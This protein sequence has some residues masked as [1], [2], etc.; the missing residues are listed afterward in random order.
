MKQ[1]KVDENPTTY[2]NK[3]L[4]WLWKMCEKIAHASQP[5]HFPFF[6]DT[7]NEQGTVRSVRSIWF[8]FHE[9]VGARE[10]CICEIGSA[11]SNTTVRETLKISLSIQ[12]KDPQCVCVR[13][14]STFWIKWT[15]NS[16]KEKWEKKFDCLWLLWCLFYWLKSVI[17][18]KRNNRNKKC[19]N[20]N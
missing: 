5:H 4:K 20:E 12:P 17:A 2:A 11:A 13:V 1:I 16:T 15:T 3:H 6:S 9:D 7:V 14:C 10:L 18:I 8:Q 19:A